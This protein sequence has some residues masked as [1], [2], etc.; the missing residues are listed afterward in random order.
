MVNQTIVDLLKDFPREP[1]VQGMVLVWDSQN[2]LPR[3]ET[4][5]FGWQLASDFVGSVPNK[6]IQE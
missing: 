3:V 6:K 1:R 2:R 5:G 4:F